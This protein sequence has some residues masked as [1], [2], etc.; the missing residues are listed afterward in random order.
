MTMF[1]NAYVQEIRF[2]YQ[3]G[4]VIYT[5]INFLLRKQILVFSEYYHLIQNE[6]NSNNASSPLIYF[7]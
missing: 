1:R 7:V 4:G 3:F 2:I 5:K 6:P